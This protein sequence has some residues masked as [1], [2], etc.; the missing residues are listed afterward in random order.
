MQLRILWATRSC[1]DSPELLFQVVQRDLLNLEMLA[2]LHA[3]ATDEQQAPLIGQ[4]PV[5]ESVVPQ[6]CG[7]LPGTLT[8][9]TLEIPAK[10]TDKD[11]PS[12]CE[13]RRS[14]TLHP[15]ATLGLR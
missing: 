2:G 6:L 3:G 1:G 7:N 14:E 9:K 8:I 5:E 11:L 15:S 12:D 13:R 10:S 4:H